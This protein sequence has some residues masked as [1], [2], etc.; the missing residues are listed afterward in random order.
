V[1]EPYHW[2]QTLS[3]LLTAPFSLEQLAQQA[4][5]KLEAI[6]TSPTL[7]GL[8][9]DYE[10]HIG[11]AFVQLLIASRGWQADLTVVGGTTQRQDALLGSCAERVVRKASTP[12]FVAKRP[13]TTAARQ[14]LVPTDF[15]VCARKAAEEALALAERFG[16]QICFFH[17]LELSSFYLPTSGMELGAPPPLPLLTPEDFEGEWRAFLAELPAL[18]DVS[19]EKQVM[20]GRAATTI[21]RQAEER[22][23]DMIVIGTHGRTGLAHMLVGSVAEEVVRMAPCSVLTIRPDAFQFELP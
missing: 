16:G 13:F 20:E 9:V 12:V 4:G 19:W 23:A 2:Y 22:H 5:E 21:V 14:F 15:S 3:H 6:V 1:V 11:K 7:T 8:R 10:V 18:S 17:V